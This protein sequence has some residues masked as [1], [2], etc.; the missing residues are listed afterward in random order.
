[1]QSNRDY[2]TENLNLRQQIDDLE[3]ENKELRGI[4]FDLSINNS[5]LKNEI[6]YLKDNY[7]NAINILNEIFE[8]EIKQRNGKYYIDYCI[9]LNNELSEENAIALKEVL[10]NE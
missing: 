3:K 6:F 7:Q 10:E 1:M 9:V 5:S 2:A 8:F 4:N